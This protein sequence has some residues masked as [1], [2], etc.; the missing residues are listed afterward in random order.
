M[1]SKHHRNF[2]IIGIIGSWLAG[3]LI[4]L[5]QVVFNRVGSVMWFFLFGA[6]FMSAF[7][8]EYDKILDIEKLKRI[9]SFFLIANIIMIM[10]SLCGFM[11]TLSPYWFA[12][13]IKF[14]SL[15]LGL[16]SLMAICWWYIY[17]ITEV[18]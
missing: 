16:P 7:K 1:F 12:K 2:L 4:S 18:K 15:G 5:F 10:F 3:F 9:S 14:V 8:T 17:K 13:E 6:I 11:L